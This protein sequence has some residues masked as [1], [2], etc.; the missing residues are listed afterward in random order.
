[1]D[2]FDCFVKIY[3]SRNRQYNGQKNRQYNGQKNRQYNGQKNRQYNGQKKKDTTTNND[4]HYLGTGFYQT[5]S[6]PTL[7]IFHL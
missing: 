6:K 1:M 5:S 4:L 3:K 2:R 7:Q